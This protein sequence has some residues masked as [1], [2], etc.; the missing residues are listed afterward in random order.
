M[1]VLTQ[2]VWGG[3]R[4]SAFLPSYQVLWMLLVQHVS[5]SASSGPVAYTIQ[6]FC[7][8]QP[9]NGAASPATLSG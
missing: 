2:S 1:K 8:S 7:F 4:D 3:T 6:R 5:K 9:L